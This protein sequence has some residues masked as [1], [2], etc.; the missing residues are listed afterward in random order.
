MGNV[1]MQTQVYY[2]EVEIQFQSWSRTLYTSHITPL[3]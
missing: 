1:L 2:T 3:K